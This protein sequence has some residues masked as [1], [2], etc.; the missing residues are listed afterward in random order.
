MME[1]GEYRGN[2][3]TPGGRGHIRRVPGSTQAT[4]LE[5]RAMFSCPPRL[6]VVVY[7]CSW[8][9]LAVT[10]EKDLVLA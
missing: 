8:D 7:A 1:K 10:P 9:K 2:P 3:L 6:C 5:L 4:M